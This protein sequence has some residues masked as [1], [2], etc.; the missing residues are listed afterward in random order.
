MNDQPPI[1]QLAEIYKA[2]K[3]LGSEI[4]SSGSGRID[5]W[6]DQISSVYNRMQHIAVDGDASSEQL[7]LAMD[8]RAILADALA[9]AIW[10]RPSDLSLLVMLRQ[11]HNDYQEDDVRF[12]LAKALATCEPCPEWIGELVVSNPDQLE[13]HMKMLDESRVAE[14]RKLYLDFQ[15]QEVF[16]QLV[17]V[18]PDTK[19][20]AG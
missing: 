20:N 11:L 8:A 5:I 4:P 19:P 12:A 17:R 14:I 7:G 1:D 6:I 13:E 18:A 15:E 3:S 10:L 9:D 16:E 2:A